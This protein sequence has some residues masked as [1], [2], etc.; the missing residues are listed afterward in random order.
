M[1]MIHEKNESLNFLMQFYSH[2]ITTR[3]CLNPTLK[4]YSLLNLELVKVSI[5]QNFDRCLWEAG[6]I[7]N[8]F[9]C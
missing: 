8:T 1:S 2:V 4:K 6:I 7:P 5:K 3:I 9:S